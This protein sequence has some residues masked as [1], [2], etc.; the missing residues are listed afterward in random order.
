MT[1]EHTDQNNDK[2]YILTYAVMFQLQRTYD[3]LMD[4]AL[5]KQDKT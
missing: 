3:Q 5:Q 4:P 2:E 1:Q